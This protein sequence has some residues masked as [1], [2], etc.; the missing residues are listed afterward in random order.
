MKAAQWLQRASAETRSLPQEKLADLIGRYRKSTSGSMYEVNIRANPEDFLDWDKPIKE[1]PHILKAIDEH[2]GDPEIVLS[3]MTGSQNSTGADFHTAMG[4]ER[5]AKDVAEKLNQM[6]IKGI[7]YFD[8][9]SRKEGEGSRNY[10]VFDDKLVNV[11][12][13][14]AFGGTV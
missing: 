13:K 5:K 9:G 4:G 6:G 2:I 8:A 3:R 14:Y 10:V 7:K 11:K 12:R 1:Q